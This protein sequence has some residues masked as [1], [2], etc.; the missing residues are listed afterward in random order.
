M[1]GPVLGTQYKNPKKLLSRRFGE[2]KEIDNKIKQ[3][4]LIPYLT[5][6]HRQAS[7]CLTRGGCGI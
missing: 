2:Q 1:T 7:L 4:D 3:L 5:V 6:I